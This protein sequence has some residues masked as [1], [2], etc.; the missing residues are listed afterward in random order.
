MV[1]MGPYKIPEIQAKH[2]SL[3][4]ELEKID[5]GKVVSTHELE[6]INNLIACLRKRMSHCLQSVIAKRNELA[7]L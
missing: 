4:D 1:I 6:D 3:K 2:A 7:Y 5:Y